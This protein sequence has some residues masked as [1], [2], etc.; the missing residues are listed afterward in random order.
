MSGPSWHEEIVAEIK[1][2]FPDDPAS[3]LACSSAGLVLP[4]AAETMTLDLARIL[5]ME[6]ADKIAI[7]ALELAL[8]ACKRAH[9]ENER[10]TQS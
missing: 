7:A 2:T 6:M 8:K 1:A 5:G 3:Q 9:A 10:R 4:K